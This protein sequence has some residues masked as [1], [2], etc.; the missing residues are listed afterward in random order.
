MGGGWRGSLPRSV[1]G[2]SSCN[3]RPLRRHGLRLRLQE[4]VLRSLG[5][6]LVLLLALRGRRGRLRHAGPRRAVAGGRGRARARRS[7]GAVRGS[8]SGQAPRLALGF[9]LLHDL[10]QGLHL[11]PRHVHLLLLPLPLGRSPA[12]RFCNAKIFLHL[13]VYSSK[14]HRLTEKRSF[15]IRVLG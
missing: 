11:V 6:R 15:C 13:L 10:A 1:R 8:C 14:F 2:P 9:P 5:R 3:V 4:A 12:L 7:R